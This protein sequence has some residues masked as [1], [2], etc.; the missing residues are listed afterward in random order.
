MYSSPASLRIILGR[1]LNRSFGGNDVFR[2]R[3]PNYVLVT[4][5]MRARPLQ[6]PRICDTGRSARC[7]V[8]RSLLFVSSPISASSTISDLTSPSAT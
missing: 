3:A 4:Y 8:A 2:T 6:G 5:I 1:V 7:L